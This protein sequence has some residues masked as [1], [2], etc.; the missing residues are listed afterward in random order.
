MNNSLRYRTLLAIAFTLFAAISAEA[1]IKIMPLGNS[2]TKGSGST[3]DGGYRLKLWELFET[4]PLAGMIDFVGQ[5]THGPLPN[6]GN[7]FFDR[8]HEGHPGNDITETMT[9]VGATGNSTIEDVLNAETPEAILLHVGT[10]KAAAGNLTPTNFATKVGSALDDLEV[11]IDKIFLTRPSVKLC[12]ALITGAQDDMS[13]NFQFVQDYN[14][15]IPALVA[16]EAALGN[17]ISSVDLFNGA[18]LSYGLGSPDFHDL[19]HLSD[20]GYEKIA[21]AWHHHLQNVGIPEPGSLSL[22]TCVILLRARTR[23]TLCSAT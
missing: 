10:V 5:R 18:G 2:L 12:V 7:L 16:A 22:I 3:H 8:D 14:A 4:G 17:D 1:A 13:I 6:A 19:F 21:G 23:N 15:G 9:K 11:L 20:A